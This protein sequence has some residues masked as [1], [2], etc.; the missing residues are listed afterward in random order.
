MIEQWYADADLL[1]TL[2]DVLK[3]ALQRTQDTSL[4]DT[5]KKS[6]HI[7]EHLKELEQASQD[8]DEKDLSDLETMIETL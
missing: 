7:L 6:L 4:Q 8:D 5:F 2:Y 1:Q 3:H